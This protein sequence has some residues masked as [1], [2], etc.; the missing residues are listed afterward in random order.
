MDYTLL[1]PIAVTLLLSAFFSGMEIAFVSA[2]KL[3]I[4]LQEDKGFSTRL[5]AGMNKRPAMFIGTT[6]IGNTIALVF[7][8]MYM[9]KALDP[10]LHQFIPSD[11]GVMIVDTIVSTLVVLA[12]AEFLPKSLFMINPNWMLTFFALPMKLV[13][14][15]LWPVVWVTVKGSR[16]I[17]TKVLKGS[18]S[19]KRPG[20]GLMD[21][22]NYLQEIVTGG[23]VSEEFSS[24]DI[25][26]KIFHNAL[27]FK[28][29]KVRECMVPRTELVAVDMEEDMAELRKAFINSGHSKVLV[30]KESIDNIIGYCHSS[31]LFKKPKGIE[32]IL[33]HIKI[34]PETML[35]RDLM[36]EFV[37]ERKS[38]ALVVDEFGGTS[39]V[40]T[41]EDVIEEIFGDIQDEHDTE[42][43]VEQ[44]LDENNYI[45]SG[46]H[47]VDDLNEKFGFEIPEG[48][49][50]TL[51]GFIL[52]NNEDIPKVGDRIMIGN[53]T[54]IVKGMDGIKIDRVHLTVED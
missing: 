53:F 35:A 50:D 13:T 40:V 37:G 8:G 44:K 31:E 48:D 41:I 11:V 19:E 26:T 42:D 10:F 6:L 25:D 7:Y 17:I 43:L 16:L 47:E 34:V 5:L 1:V 54:V 32:D 23:E 9:A 21:L 30:Y 52:A 15:V 2:D 27:E 46:R 36:S 24:T 4:E 49:Y 18:Y 20:F 45:L 14:I 51:G 33:I 38:I 12:T 29:T 3:H 28:T 22:N 39:G